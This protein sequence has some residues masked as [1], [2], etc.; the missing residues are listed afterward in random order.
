MKVCS[1]EGCNKKHH[2]KGFCSN[3][4]HIHKRQEKRKQGLI[5]DDYS[6]SLSKLKS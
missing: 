5:E 1:V 4:Y 2:A 3:H 6:S